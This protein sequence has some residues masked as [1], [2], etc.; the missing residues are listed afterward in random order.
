MKKI[1]LVCFCGALLS[2]SLSSNDMEEKTRLVK[3]NYEP[4]DCEFLYEIKSDFS[5][6]SEQSAIDFVEKRIVEENGFGDT[7]YISK[8]DVVENDGAVFGPKN[9][10]KIKAKVY[11]CKK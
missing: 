7:Y 10:Y 4:Q 6:Y 5:G 9:T 3:L 11:N 2:C 1:I 8:Q